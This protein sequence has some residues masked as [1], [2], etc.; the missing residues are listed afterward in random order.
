MI[1][2]RIKNPNKTEFYKNFVIYKHIPGLKLTQNAMTLKWLQWKTCIRMSWGIPPWLV[3]NCVS[4]TENGSA[5]GP[6]ALPNLVWHQAC[7]CTHD[8]AGS[9]AW[10]WST[11]PEHFGNQTLKLASCLTANSFSLFWAGNGSRSRPKQPQSS[12]QLS[13]RPQEL[14]QGNIAQLQTKV[15]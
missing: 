5:H 13:S 6:D 11:F 4:E 1:M 7:T 9:D 10:C 15:H 14:M 2:W 12:W 8:Q 3:L